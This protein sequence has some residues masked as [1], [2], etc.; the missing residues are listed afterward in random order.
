MTAADVAEDAPVAA[1]EK[2][3]LQRFLHR[4]MKATFEGGIESTD[5]LQECRAALEKLHALR[6]D[7][8]FAMMN[9]HWVLGRLQEHDA[10]DGLLKKFVASAC[11]DA[12]P[13]AWFG[14]ALNQ[15]KEY[16]GALEMLG[17]APRLGDYLG[18]E[19]ALEKMRA[20]AGRGDVAGALKVHRERFEQLKA[21][22]DRFHFMYH[23]DEMIDRKDELGRA[24]LEKSADVEAD[25]RALI[26]GEKD[27]ERRLAQTMSLSSLYSRL[28]RV[29]DQ[30]AMLVGAVPGNKHIEGFRH[31]FFRT[32]YAIVETG[33]KETAN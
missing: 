24:W 13:V 17:R 10:A 11:K 5:A 1:R 12:Q 19:I 27:D 15:K 33:A 29:D 26:G 28:D 9:L 7:D 25:L 8:G 16:A 14:R 30:V 21:N 31:Y 2:A 23:R 32:A 20:H 3:A 18:D 22:L 4:A 6:P